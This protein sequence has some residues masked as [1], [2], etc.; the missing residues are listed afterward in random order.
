[1]R[2]QELRE[3]AERML[4]QVRG[5]PLVALSGETGRGVERLMPAVFATHRNW[6]TKVKTRD[7]NDWLAMAV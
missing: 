1:M 5:A 3:T 6:S 2:L 4:P 7:L